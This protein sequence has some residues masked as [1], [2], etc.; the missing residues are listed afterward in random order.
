MT[1]R[2][3]Q[4]YIFSQLG[5]EWVGKPWEKH[6][7]AALAHLRSRNVNMQFIE[8]HIHFGSLIDAIKSS[9]KVGSEISPRVNCL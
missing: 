6:P 9:R 2:G 8:R 1:L 4:V 7:Q 5:G 3:K